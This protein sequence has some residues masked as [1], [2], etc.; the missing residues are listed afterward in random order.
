MRCRQRRRRNRRRQRRWHHRRRRHH[1][2]TQRRWHDRRR[3]HHR[4]RQRRRRHRRR[5]RR[6]HHRRRRRRMPMTAVHRPDGRLERLQPTGVRRRGLGRGLHPA[7]PRSEL[8][9]GHPDGHVQPD[10]LGWYQPAEPFGQQ[11]AIPAN[12]TS[13]A[14]I[15]GPSADR[16]NEVNHPDNTTGTMTVTGTAKFY[17]GTLPS[18][19]IS[20]NPAT[21]AGV[22]R[23][24]AKQPVWWDGTGTPHTLM[25]MWDC[26]DGGTVR[27]VSTTPAGVCIWR[28][29][30]GRGGSGGPHRGVERH[31]GRQE[32][33]DREGAG[34]ASSPLVQRLSA[35]RRSS[36]TYGLH[37]PQSGGARAGTC[38][39]AGAAERHRRLWLGLL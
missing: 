9:V 6:R 19:F 21:M 23:S 16:Y 1:R 35:G 2:R 20:C 15:Y 22:R 7:P 32:D 18:D 5:Q 25:V 30:A 28:A 34:R 11:P 31:G 4:R 3:R 12:S 29:A 36:R 39:G 38:S 37:K 33:P 13:T 24:T 8:R 27:N 17:E 26:A 14:T 10:G